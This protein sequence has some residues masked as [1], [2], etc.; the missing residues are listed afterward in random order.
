MRG[1][2]D[3]KTQI[4]K[5]I[6]G[7]I[8][9][10]TYYTITNVITYFTKLRKLYS[11][12]SP[13]TDDRS[14]I[15][16]ADGR[17]SHGGIADRLKGIV[18]LYNYSKA[19]SIP[20]GISFN[21]P[22]ELTD[23]LVPNRYDWVDVAKRIC[24]NSKTSKPVILKG[25]HNDG[26]SYTESKLGKFLNNLQLHVYTNIG[27]SFENFKQDF[28]ELFKPSQALEEQIKIN[29]ENIGCPY[30]SV[31]FRF[32]QLLGDF[33]EGGYNTL[34][35]NEQELYIKKCIEAIEM[36]KLR[37]KD[38][39]RVVVT[40]DSTTF[41]QRASE[42]LKYVYVIPGTMSHMDYT[43]NTHRLGYIKSFLD[44]FIISKARKVYNFSTGEM[45]KHS[46]FAQTA[47]MIG[48]VEYE[49]IRQE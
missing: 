40:S 7:I 3:F 28:A 45:Y 12:Q 38:I 9:L 21:H 35:K 10:D 17:I 8:P 27:F 14:I 6:L 19:K 18:A 26:W 46:G 32:Q 30:I 41:L 15:Y 39:Y 37:H 2:N 24:F 4:R 48:G 31:T 11:I 16:V 36:I 20:F 25:V 47:A 33:E 42:K 22:F 34:N 43:V 29:L 23:Y 5:V 1:L 49:N 44:L 13:P